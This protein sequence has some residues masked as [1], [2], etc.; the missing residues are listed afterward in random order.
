MREK[1]GG[2]V[3]EIVCKVGEKEAQ[4]ALVEL[5]SGQWVIVLAKEI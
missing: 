1:N 5:S 4:V 3:V 2:Q